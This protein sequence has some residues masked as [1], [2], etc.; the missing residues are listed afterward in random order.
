MDGTYSNGNPRRVRI[1]SRFAIRDGA[2]GKSCEGWMGP[3]P[4]GTHVA[5]VSSHVLPYMCEPAIGG[6][7]NSIQTEVSEVG[8]CPCS[9]FTHGYRFYSER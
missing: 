5:S 1:S 6:K 9:G 2:T 4:M 8:R 7:D 3:I